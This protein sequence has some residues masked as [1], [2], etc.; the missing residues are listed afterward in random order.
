MGGHSVGWAAEHH[1][2][3]FSS[4]LRV[5]DFSAELDTSV[6]FCQNLHRFQTAGASGRIA[7]IEVRMN[8]MAKRTTRSTVPK[9]PKTPRA[10]KTSTY[11]GTYPTEATS[12][13]KASDIGG[14]G[15]DATRNDSM[16]SE[17]SE[18][19]IRMRAYR[20]YLERG[21]TDG[22]HFEDWMEAERELRTGR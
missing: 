10:S 9:A 6:I 8:V 21:G 2:V 20:R 18:E 7:L 12:A 3:A 13:D 14:P 19:E 22:L 1:V 11:S 17:P 4:I 16:G 15:D 5:G